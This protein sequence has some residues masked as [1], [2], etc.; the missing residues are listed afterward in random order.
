M[1]GKPVRILFYHNETHVVGCSISSHGPGLA[2]PAATTQSLGENFGLGSKSRWR[3]SDHFRSVLCYM[4]AHLNLKSPSS[5]KS[6]SPQKGAYHYEEIHPD[7]RKRCIR[8]S[9]QRFLPLRP[10]S[11]RSAPCRGARGNQV[12]LNFCGGRCAGGE[13]CRYHR[14][15][16]ASMFL[17]T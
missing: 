14:V 4:H 16:R 7:K 9:L 10:M 12:F 17:M 13:L 15:A 3:I 2:S 1:A 6:R 8:M 5:L 11:L